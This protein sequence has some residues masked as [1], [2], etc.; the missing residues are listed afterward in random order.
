M[1]SELATANQTSSVGSVVLYF[2]PRRT[3]SPKRFGR[4]FSGQASGRYNYK[5][6]KSTLF[7]FLTLQLQTWFGL[8]LSTLRSE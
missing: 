3:I 1:T 4:K 8:E 7:F 6:R 2:D 5:F